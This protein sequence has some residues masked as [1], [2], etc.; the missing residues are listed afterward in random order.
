MRERV[1]HIGVVAGVVEICGDV[2]GH[3][4]VVQDLD[5]VYPGDVPLLRGGVEENVVQR[6]HLQPGVEIRKGDGVG[7]C[8]VAVRAEQQEPAGGVKIGAGSHPGEWDE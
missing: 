4:E 5:D 6:T 7:A 2:V 8:R 1:N 3:G